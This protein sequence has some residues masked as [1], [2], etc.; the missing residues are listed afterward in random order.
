MLADFHNHSCLSPCGS[1]EMS[2]RTIARRAAQAG[3]Q[4][5]ALTD[6]N[7]ARNTPAFAEA[8]RA[9]GIIPL[10]GLEITT[11]EECH[12]LAIFDTPKTALKMGKWVWR[13]LPRYPLDT[14]YYGDQPVVDT[15]E[16]IV[17]LVDILLTSAIQKSFNDVQAETS[18][19][20]GL[21][22]PAHINR[23]SFSVE[24]QL[25][26]LPRGTYDAIEVLRPQAAAYQKR[27]PDIPVIT[28]SDAHV[29]AQIAQA[30]FE[31]PIKDVSIPAIRKALQTRCKTAQA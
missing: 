28:S 15:N 9:E 22:I 3:V 1:L 17:E 13:H 12:V 8:C 16:N 18:R 20:G 26:F 30:S 10:A 29:P 6:H 19:L 23:H 27:Y 5:M 24:S 14:E 11:I 31:L 7:S 4:I 21:F 2:P 25:G